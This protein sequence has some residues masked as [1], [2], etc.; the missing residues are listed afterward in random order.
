MIK[1]AI[2]RGRMCELA[3]DL[4]RSAMGRDIPPGGSLFLVG[5]FSHIDQLMGVPMETII[6]EVDLMPEVQA[7]LL[8]REGKAGAILAG[9]EAYTNA[10]WNTAQE[11]L[12][13]V[14]VPPHALADLYLDSLT[15]AASRMPV[16]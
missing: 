14:G 1:D 7:A 9:I 15:W 6:S 3:G 10:D 4:A 11:D 13:E 2:L 8:E 16:H 5:L 12:A